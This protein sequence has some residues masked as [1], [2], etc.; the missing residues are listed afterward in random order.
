MFE[1]DEIL[2]TTCNWWLCNAYLANFMEK[3][4]PNLLSL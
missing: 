3:R 2:E 1:I 4:L